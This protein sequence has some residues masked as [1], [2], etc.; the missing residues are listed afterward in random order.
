MKAAI[1]LA[2]LALTASTALAG[3]TKK[4]YAKSC[5]AVW[6]AEQTALQ[7]YTHVVIDK[8]KRTASFA[9]NSVVSFTT[10]LEGNGDTCTISVQETAPPLSGHKNATNFLKKLDKTLEAQ[11]P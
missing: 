10:S 1:V 8:N 4:S 6:T 9:D 11:K 7:T 2:V 5:D 3:P